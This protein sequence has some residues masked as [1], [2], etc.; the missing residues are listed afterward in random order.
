MVWRDCKGISVRNNSLL[1]KW[2]WRFLEERYALCHQVI[3]SIYRTHT[4]GWDANTI[5]RW[6]HHCPW[7]AI[8]QVFPKF[9][10]YIHLVV[11]DGLRIQ[12]WENLLWGDQPLCSQFWGLFKIV[13]IKNLTIS[14]I[15]G[16]INTFS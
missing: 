5:V 14:S 13:T 9:S 7:K 8:A 12:F 11:G 10:K 4:N 6:S 15:L 16:S 3:V 2:I 1:G